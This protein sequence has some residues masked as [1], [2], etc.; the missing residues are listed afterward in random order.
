[1]AMDSLKLVAK[2]QAFQSEFVFGCVNDMCKL[3][4]Q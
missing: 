4:G 2:P 3:K 1:M